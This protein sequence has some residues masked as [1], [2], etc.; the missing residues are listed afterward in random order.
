MQLQR[1]YQIHAMILLLEEAGDFSF[2]FIMPTLRD[3][4]MD[5]EI[6]GE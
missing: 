6:E 2:S 3:R 5:L 1:L 4:M